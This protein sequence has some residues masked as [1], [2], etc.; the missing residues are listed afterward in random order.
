MGEVGLLFL[1]GDDLDF[2]EFD[3]VCYSCLWLK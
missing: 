2:L 1:L 3:L